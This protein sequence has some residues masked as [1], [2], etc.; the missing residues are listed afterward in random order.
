MK[1]GSSCIYDAFVR[2]SQQPKLLMGSSRCRFRKPNSYGVFPQRRFFFSKT[3][4]VRRERLVLG[5]E[6]SCDDTGVAIVREDGSILA[7]AI[8]S[9]YSVHQ[10]YGGVVPRLAKFEHEKNLQVLLRQ[11]MLD[12]GLM[13][14]KENEKEAEASKEEAEG[15]EWKEAFRKLSAVAVTAGPGLALCLRV[16]LNEAK[17]MALRHSLPFIA[18]NHLEAHA[19]V[20]RLTHP[21]LRF[22]FLCLLISG[23]HTQ[24][25]VA[26]DV[27]HFTFLGGTVDDSVGEAFDK[28]AQLLG[29]YQ[30]ANMQKSAGALLEEMASQGDATR[31]LF[32]VPLKEHKN[33]DFSFAG[34]KTA[35]VRQM[36]KLSSSSIAPSF[37]ELQRKNPTLATTASSTPFR[38][39]TENSEKE[40]QEETEPQQPEAKKDEAELQQIR[41]DIAASFQECV[42]RH[43]EERTHRALSWCQQDNNGVLSLQ[44]LVV[45]GGVACNKRIRQMV[46][47]LADNFQ[48]ECIF[49]PVR[50][51]TDNGVMV[52]WTGMERLRK[53]LVDNATTARFHP[54]LVSLVLVLFFFCFLFFFFCSSFCSSLSSSCDC[55]YFVPLFN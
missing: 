28:T 10:Q 52:A 50:L 9:Q 33:C 53:D 41:C 46:Q 14:H 23:G 26:H 21:H 17:E 40:A 31:F 42:V 29:V 12:S 18:V 22:P 49:P 25:L 37:S 30:Q 5:I 47:R 20:A 48:V 35:V 13:R 54:R 32:T 24:L 51:C 3:A 43:L 4:S 39:V 34:L 36:A 27:G 19:M 45:C 1:K 55:S 8:S 44:A 16:G 15:E 2:N 38:I 6:T 7:E 11:V